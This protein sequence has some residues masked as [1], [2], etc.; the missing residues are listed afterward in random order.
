MI[1]KL[2]PGDRNSYIQMTQ[3]F[4]HSSAVTHCVPQSFF[5][6]T[7]SELMASDV[8]CE[9]FV[10]AD[11][12]AVNAYALVSKTYS[13]EAGGLCVWVEELYVMPSARGRGIGTLLLE[14]IEREFPSAARFRL[15]L[16]PEN[17]SAEKLYI[18]HGYEP[19]SY[20]QMIKDIR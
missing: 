3:A 19:L 20:K 9:C 15:E 14:R 1:R 6:K 5:E 8:Y 18:R 12:E 7:F 4:Y 16:T 11:G 2:C 17:T 10:H 13:Q